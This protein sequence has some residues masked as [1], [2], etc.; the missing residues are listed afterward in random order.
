LQPRLAIEPETQRVGARYG[1]IKGQ[2]PVAEHGEIT[3]RLA[4]CSTA[5]MT[6]DDEDDQESINR[7]DGTPYG[8]LQRREEP[9]SCEAR[10]IVVGGGQAIGFTNQSVEHCVSAA[11]IL[12]DPDNVYRSLASREEYECIYSAEECLSKE[13]SEPR[14][15]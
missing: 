6:Q 2:S 7:N 11:P 9:R 8:Q 5:L 10:G 15:D 3:E 14:R 1:V 13:K 4:G 12:S